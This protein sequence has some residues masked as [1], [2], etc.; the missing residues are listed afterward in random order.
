MSKVTPIQIQKY[1][2]GLDYPASKEDLISHA[3][4]AG[5]DES[6]LSILEEL[7]DEEFQTPVDVSKAIGEID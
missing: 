1:L 5:A 2:K 7:S 6:I 4:E 3:E